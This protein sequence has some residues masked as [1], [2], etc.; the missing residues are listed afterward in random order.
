MIKFKIVA[1]GNI[2]EDYLRQA[3]NEYTKRINKYAKCEIVECSEAK[4]NPN[5][6]AFS[7]FK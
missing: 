3:I 4:L 5:P 7:I 1:V 2:K 6:S